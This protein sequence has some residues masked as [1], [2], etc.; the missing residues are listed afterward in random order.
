MWFFWLTVPLVAAFFS[1]QPILAAMVSFISVLA[2]T[3]LH[4]ISNRIEDPFKS[5]PPLV[6][7]DL[8]QLQF[9]EVLVAITDTRRPLGFAD[10]LKNVHD[11][12]GYAALFNAEFTVR[13]F[14]CSSCIERDSKCHV[15]VAMNIVECH[16]CVVLVLVLAT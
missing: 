9:N 12:R 8:K 16:A 1:N 13:S 7:L 2:F 14:M 4:E 11:D 3:T 6:P 15:I 10:L 5:Y